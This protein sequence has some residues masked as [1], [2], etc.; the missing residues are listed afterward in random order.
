MGDWTFGKRR[1]KGRMGLGR[2]DAPGSSRNLLEL[3][4]QCL[5]GLSRRH[6][7]RCRVAELSVAGY[8]IE[9]IRSFESDQDGQILPI[10]EAVSRM[11]HLFHG[12]ILEGRHAA[13]QQG[14]EASLFPLR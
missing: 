5:E 6:G 2:T 10:S 9:A 3:A 7:L 14:D 11:A 4:E 1:Q 13:I 12:W 8:E